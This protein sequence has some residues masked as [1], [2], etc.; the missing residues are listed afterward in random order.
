MPT[1]A[2]ATGNLIDFEGQDATEIVAGNDAFTIGGQ[3]RPDKKYF[4][5]KNKTKDELVLTFD[6]IALEAGKK[7]TLDMDIM[8][9]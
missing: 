7:Y 9:T 5:S 4:Y 1:K 6:D 2:A 8:I 3:D